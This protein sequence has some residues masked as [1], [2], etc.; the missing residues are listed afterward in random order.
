M[1]QSDRRRAWRW[2]LLW[3]ALVFAVSGHGAPIISEFMASSTSGLA[4]EEGAF[5]DWIEIHNPDGVPVS[6]GGYHLTDNATHLHGWTFPSMT[7]GPG[8]YLTV[9]A[10]GKDRTD[11]TGRLHTDF[12]LSAAGEYLALVAPDGVSV[13]SE[14]APAYPAQFE[15]VSFG[16][17][18]SGQTAVWSYFPAPTP[19]VP[20]AGGTRAGPTV[21][22]LDPNPPQPDPGP[23]TVV[24]EV[25]PTND[26]VSTVRLYYRRMF[27]AETMV[28]MMDDGTGGDGKPGDGIW[29]AVIPG[30]AFVPGE[31]TRWRIVAT[32]AK[33]TET[34]APAFRS[35][36]DSEQYF[37][38]VP[39]DA[40]I[41]TA[42]PVLRWFTSSPGGAGTTTGSRGAIHYGG[43]FYDN[44]LFTVHGQSSAGFPKKSYNI[45]FNRD[46]HFLWST[47]APRVADID[48]LSN[49]AD[50][51]KARDVLAYEVM[52]ESG[53]AAHFAFTVRVEQNGGFFSTADLVEDGDEIYLQRAGLNRNGALY[54]IYANVL[55][56]DAGNTATSGVEKKTRKFENNADLQALIDGLDLTGPALERYLYD[57]IDI[58]GC[59]NL[60]AASSV[61][62]NIDMHQ[63]NWY[64]YCDSGR[65]GEWTI[66]P[67][68][69]DLS[70]GRYWT[71]QDTYYDNRLYTD[72]YVVNGDAIRLV[73]HMFANPNMRAM[74][75]RR[76]RTLTDRFLQPPPAAGMPQGDLYYE[77]RLDELSALIDP[78]AIVPSD[79]RLD[80]EKWGAWLQGG[81]VVRY[82]NSSPAVESMAKAILRWK[83][84]YLPGRR[85]FIYNTQIAG[86][87]GEIPLPQDS[88][89]SSTNFTALV[90]Q[91][92]SAK[93]I[94]PAAGDL[95]LTWTGAPASEPF[96]TAGW[97]SGTTG[98]G[99]ER[100]TGYETLIGLDVDSRMQGNTTVFIRIEFQVADPS[101]FDRL[102]LRMKYDDGFVAYLNGAVLASAN[103]PTPLQ[104]NSAATSSREANPAAF[105]PFDVTAGLGHLRAGRN[106]LA[107]HGLNDSVTSSDMII[108]PELHGGRFV[109]P[110][111]HEPRLEFGT[112]EIGPA[113]GIQD[114][115]YVQ[116]RNPSPIAVDVSGWQLAGGIQHTFAA[117]TVLPQNGS[118]YVCPSAAAFR[119][120]TVSPRGGEGLLV[121]GGYHGHLAN[122]GEALSIIDSRG[123]TNNA[124]TYASRLSNPQRYL[125]VSEIMYHPALDDRAEFIELLN[126]SDSVTLDL[127]GIRFTQGVQFD[128][129]GSA[130]TSLRPGGRVL[131]VRDL[132]AA[133]VAYGTNLPVAGVFANGSALSNGGEPIKLEDAGNGTIREFAYGDSAPWPADTESGYSLVLVAPETNPDPALPVSW[134]A[135]ARPGGS[136]GGSDVVPFPRN[137]TGDSDVNGERDL[138][139]YV[140]GSDLGLP[141]IRSKIIAEPDPSG[142]PATL[143]LSYPVSLGA[144]RAHVGVS[145]STNLVTWLDAAPHL[146][147]FSR[148]ALGDGRA[149]M[150]WR[151]ISPLRDAP[152]IFL[153][154]RAVE[155]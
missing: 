70:H 30:A 154:L 94:V 34:H 6:L 63:K 79:A 90:S 73:A 143:R 9:F 69:L 152:R 53:V 24:A 153:R 14:F 107:I 81:T 26:K 111:S 144:E 40:R 82:T 19:G 22:V 60:L 146:E 20:N 100:A 17:V 54:K 113:S 52:R 46:H 50:K 27:A 137:P 16:L 5:S 68:D 8:A 1:P 35:P 56:K 124:T 7:L 23:L 151:V 39:R 72:G 102:Q 62:R 130:V 116:I 37:G 96:A 89:A 51:S 121:Q 58:P 28:P 149:L 33:G 131:V 74:I 78:P 139:D 99:Y 97:I 95:G 155:P 136:P 122:S 135:S 76:I 48:L 125:V 15:N 80:F 43:E 77:R 36:T 41:A 21:H 10:S 109:S 120:R 133:T 12:Q 11:P 110:S 44:V 132:A 145:Y 3:I 112:L 117:G 83:N 47:N 141:P 55:D 67:W 59:V 103:A 129:T 115:E 87:G 118:I 32:D 29:T 140:L 104:W 57:H 42:L 88:S 134:R 142:S 91:G 66:L 123:A 64:A 84:E 147:W 65:S 98:V 128:F 18:Q 148:E 45:D 75:L 119:A 31:M 13:V 114:Q 49:W 126:I 150:T 4:D 85:K 93:A 86:R 92:A 61:I 127:T 71:T 106:V 2:P 101:A 25:F 108:V 138:V 38:T 105:T